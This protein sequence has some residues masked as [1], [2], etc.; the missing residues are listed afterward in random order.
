MPG[1][2]LW[3]TICCQKSPQPDHKKSCK[4]EED[5]LGQRIGW[6]GR[7]VTLCLFPNLFQLLLVHSL[8]DGKSGAMTCTLTSSACPSP[9]PTRAGCHT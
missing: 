5:E 1:L 3:L 9:D 8:H 7:K 4:C 6:A 2:S